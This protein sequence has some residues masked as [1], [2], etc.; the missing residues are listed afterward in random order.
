MRNSSYATHYAISRYSIR[1]FNTVAE[2]FMIAMIIIL[3]IILCDDGCT[4]I[5]YKQEMS[6]QN[7][8]K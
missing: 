2:P 6:V 4:I 8:G 1:E 7:N 3:I 5:L